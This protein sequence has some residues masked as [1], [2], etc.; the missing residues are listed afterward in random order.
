VV[1]DKTARLSVD[2]E[3][4]A[5]ALAGL[6]ARGAAVTILGGVVPIEAG[7]ED[8]GCAFLSMSVRAE[9]STGAAPSRDDL[10]ALR[11]IIK[12]HHGSLRLG[13][14]GYEMRFSLYLP[15]LRGA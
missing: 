12:N 7:A 2:A 6:A 1:Q 9:H 11:R 8:T 4:M 10:A 14:L 3:E 5:Q 13:R 15:M